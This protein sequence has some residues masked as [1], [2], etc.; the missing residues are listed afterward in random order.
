MTKLKH[1]LDQLIWNGGFEEGK[2]KERDRIKALLLKAIA[3]VDPYGL[4][5]ESEY[6]KS[7][8]VDEVNKL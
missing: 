8:C 3:D 7:V 4:N 6:W 1:S 5:E 2:K